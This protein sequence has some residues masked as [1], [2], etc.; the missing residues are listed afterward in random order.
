MR[1]TGD[2]TSL[3]DR[4]RRA[5]QRLVIGF[6]GT[7]VSADHRAFIREARPAGFI[8]F[9]RNVEEPAQVRELNRELASLLPADT[10]A[11]LS[12]D[13]EGGQVQRIRATEWPP[14]RWL[15]NAD[16]VGLTARV[17]REMARELRA[18]GFN[19]NWAPDADVDSNPANPVIGDR[20]FSSNPATCA[21]H[22]AA[23][24][25]AMQAE[26]VAACAKHFPGHGDTTVDSH[27]ELPVVEKTPADLERCELIPFRAAVN[28]GVLAVM[29]AH[30][31]YPA[32][33][34]RYP[35]TLSSAILRDRLRPAPV[36]QRADGD[37][38]SSRQP[39]QPARLDFGGV[40]VS[41]DLEMKALRGRYPLEHEL[42]LACRA[43]VDL[44]LIC[45]DLEMQWTAW[46]TLVRL[47]ETD[48]AHDD[49][50]TDSW[51]RLMALREQVLK[52]VPPEPPLSVVGAQAHKDLALQ[53]AAR[54]QG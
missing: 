52:N 9:G 45:S 23:F 54:G 20:S 2:Q 50:S 18:M 16:D 29:T 31:L 27:L 51:K 6:E 42:D 53:V 17:A 4:K 33:D 12:V 44:F 8:L 7:S 47:Q 26:G 25:R 32:L 11:L 14:M 38:Q 13:Q 35:A 19:V 21:R 37:V 1:A 10:P 46:E 5:G 49:L 40:V 24:V 30:V 28:A 3:A 41:D 48:K 43:T 22:V 36:R 34:E 15:G 39:I